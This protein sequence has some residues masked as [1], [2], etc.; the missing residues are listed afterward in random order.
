M[1][2]E[3][4]VLD[5]C[6]LTQKFSY[7]EAYSRPQHRCRSLIIFVLPNSP[8]YTL[9]PTTGL[10]VPGGVE[11]YP[12]WRRPVIRSSNRTARRCKVS[13]NMVNL[14]TDKWQ[15]DCIVCSACT[16]PFSN[17]RLLCCNLL[18][19]PLNTKRRP[20][21][22]KTQFLPRSKHFSSRI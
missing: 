8:R 4:L 20:L 19:S 11:R 6:S 15:Q 22:L 18:L 10:T 2:N 17:T 3:P 16:V 21:Y 7:T 14:S 9:D 12:C 5:T 1:T 13:Y